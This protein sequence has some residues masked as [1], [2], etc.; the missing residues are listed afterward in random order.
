MVA[1]KELSVYRPLGVHQKLPSILAVVSLETT[2]RFGEQNPDLS[3]EVEIRN[4]VKIII[5]SMSASFNFLP[6]K[7]KASL[8][9]NG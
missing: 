8:S 5:G 4:C 1:E 7:N 9:N 6:D 2:Q 3:V